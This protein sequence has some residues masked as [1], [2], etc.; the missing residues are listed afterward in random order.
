[1]PAP[2]AG[3]RE[4]AGARRGQGPRSHAVSLGGIG[5]APE[6]FARSAIMPHIC[7]TTRLRA[8]MTAYLIALALAGLMVIAVW[9]GF[10]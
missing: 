1:M 9:E 3:T 2:L 4:R 10:T 5:F 8:V 6:M 7:F